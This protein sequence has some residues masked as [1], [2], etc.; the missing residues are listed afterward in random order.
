M[1]VPMIPLK[2]LL[3]QGRITEATI[4]VAYILEM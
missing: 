4:A 2:L 1:T 3:S